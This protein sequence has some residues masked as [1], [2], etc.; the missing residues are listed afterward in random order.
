MGRTS[1]AK[2]RLL[3]AAFDLIW[4]NSYGAVG[5]DQICEQAGVNK[6]SFYHFFPSKSDLALATFEDQ[7]NRRRPE[8][9]AMFSPLVPPLERLDRW[10][11]FILGIQ[12]T[13]ARR[14]GQVCGCPFVNVGTELGTQDVR[15]RDKVAEL[16]SRSQQYLESA[17]RD[18]MAVALIPEGDAAGLA[19]M[20]HALSLGLQVQAKVAN[21]PELLGVL[22]PA[23]RRLLGIPS[24][25]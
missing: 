8:F 10:C 17:L 15:L 13:M 11:A 25:T 18:A 4:T 2:E 3:D 9:D 24:D 12:R 5:V 14:F 1:D 6:G 21:D 7:W 16:F 19:R 20:I 22:A 23:I